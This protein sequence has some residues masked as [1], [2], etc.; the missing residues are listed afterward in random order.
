MAKKNVFKKAVAVL[1][2]ALQ[3]SGFLSSDAQAAP[4]LATVVSESAIQINKL[5]LSE[6]WGR[7]QN[8][9]HG[10][11][12]KTL[13]VIEDA[14][15]VSSAQKSIWKLIE[16]IRARYGA[17]ALHLEGLNESS[18]LALEHSFPDRDWLRKKIEA[19]VVAQ[20][21]SGGAAALILS[22]LLMPQA[23]ESKELYYRAVE[24]YQSAIKKQESVL[25]R[26]ERAREIISKSKQKSY[27]T[28][29]LKWDRFISED[30]FEALPLILQFPD[31]SFAEHFPHLEAVRRQVQIQNHLK[32]PAIVQFWQRCLGSLAKQ[33]A[34]PA[35]RL[36]LLA[37]QK[38]VQTGR[39]SV[40]QSA[41]K[42]EQLLPADLFNKVN[43]L[44]KR[45]YHFALRS[46]REW[47]EIKT[48][49]L[50]AEYQGFLIQKLS[51][52]F[53]KSAQHLLLKQTLRIRLLEKLVRMELSLSDWQ[54]VKRMNLESP[55]WQSFKDFYAVQFK[56]EEKMQKHIAAS[57][58][59]SE[60]VVFVSGGFHKQG[61][62]QIAQKQ[63][64]NFAVITPS[65]DSLEGADRYVELMQGNIGWRS[66]MK[67][68]NGQVNLQKA[69]WSYL[70]QAYAKDHPGQVYDL[71]LNWRKRL[72]L[73]LADLKKLNQAVKIA[74]PLHGWLADFMSEPTRQRFRYQWRSHLKSPTTAQAVSQAMTQSPFLIPMDQALPVNLLVQPVDAVRKIA[75]PMGASTITEG[76]WDQAVQTVARDHFFAEKEKKIIRAWKWIRSSFLFE[77]LVSKGLDAWIQKN[78]VLLPREYRIYWVGMQKVFALSFSAFMGIGFLFLFDDRFEHFRQGFV[79][80]TIAAVF[81]IG[82]YWMGRALSSVAELYDFFVS[83]RYEVENTAREI[84]LRDQE[85]SHQSAEL[86]S[87]RNVMRSETRSDDFTL[88]GRDAKGIEQKKID[89]SMDVIRG[90]TQDVTVTWGIPAYNEIERLHRPS[91]R[92]PAGED[93][94]RVKFEQ[95]QMLRE[96]NPQFH[97]RMVFVDDGSPDLETVSLLKRLRRSSKLDP[98]QVQIL[99]LAP[100]VK[101]G[102]KGGAVHLGLNAAL[103]SIRPRGKHYIGY[104][105]MD[106]SANLLLTGLLI[107]PMAETV[108]NG[109]AIGVRR[110]KGSYTEGR[111]WQALISSLMYNWAIRLLLSPI[112]NIRDTQAGFKIFSPE[113]LRAILP[114][115]RDFSFSFDSELLLLAALNK[116]QIAQVP[117]AW[118]DSVAASTFAAQSVNRGFEA[119]KTVAN[120]HAGHIREVRRSELREVNEYLNQAREG[121]A[122]LVAEVKIPRTQ[123]SVIVTIVPGRMDAITGQSFRAKITYPYF[124]GIFQQWEEFGGAVSIN[125]RDEGDKKVYEF[126]DV[127]PSG[128]WAD[129]VYELN[130]KRGVGGA[131][132]RFLIGAVGF[133]QQ[134][135]FEIDITRVYPL[136]LIFEKYSRGLNFSEIISLPVKRLIPLHW[137]NV[138]DFWIGRDAFSLEL[139][140]D[141][142][143]GFN[144]NDFRGRSW[145]DVVDKFHSPGLVF[146]SAQDAFFMPFE[147]IR[148]VKFKH[149][150]DGDRWI[151]ADV[152][153]Q[154]LDY[155]KSELIGRRVRFD[156]LTN[157]VMVITDRGVENNIGKIRHMDRYVFVRGQVD[158]AKISD[159]NFHIV[160]GYPIRRSESR[161]VLDGPEPGREPQVKINLN[162]KQLEFLNQYLGGEKLAD[163]AVAKIFENVNGL[164][165]RLNQDLHE[166]R[167]GDLVV[168]RP[169]PGAASEFKKARGWQPRGHYLL[170]V[171]DDSFKYFASIRDGSFKTRSRQPLESSGWW[172]PD[173]LRKANVT[174][175]SNLR[176]S[177]QAEPSVFALN[178]KERPQAMRDEPLFLSPDLFD[179]FIIRK[180]ESTDKR[181]EARE[182]LKVGWKGPFAG[183]HFEARS[184]QEIEA[185]LL[186]AANAKQLDVLYVD[187]DNTTFSTRGWHGSEGQIQSL[188]Q[189]LTEKFS[190]EKNARSM[191]ARLVF[192]FVDKMHAWMK[193]N[194]YFEPASDLDI[195]FYQ[196]LRKKGVRIVAVT[197]RPQKIR[198]E[199]IAT[200][201]AIFGE[202]AITDWLFTDGAGI[203]KLKAIQKHLESA[204]IAKDHALLV[205]DFH[206][207]VEA[208]DSLISTIHL[209]DIYADEK[210]L[211]VEK[212]FA[213]MRT[214]PAQK[215]LR[216][217]YALNA[218]VAA[219]DGDH[220]RQVR[221]RVRPELTAAMNQGLDQAVQEIQDFLNRSNLTW[222]EIRSPALR[223]SESRLWRFEDLQLSVRP[224][225]F[226]AVSLA[227]TLSE[228]GAKNQDAVLI[229]RD[230]ELMLPD[231][232][233]QGTGD[234]REFRFA[235][236]E[237]D[238]DGVMREHFESVRVSYTGGW[239]TLATNGSEPEAF[240]N[241]QKEEAVYL[242]GYGPNEIGFERANGDETLV[243]LKSFPNHKAN[244][245]AIKPFRWGDGIKV[246]VSE[247]AGLTRS[248]YQ[249]SEAREG[250]SRPQL[251]Q[252]KNKPEWLDKTEDARFAFKTFFGFAFWGVIFGVAFVAAAVVFTA[253]A[254]IFK[255]L[256]AY[257]DLKNAD[258]EY[259][260]TFAKYSDLSLKEKQKAVEFSQEWAVRIPPYAWIAYVS[261]KWKITGKY[262][263]P[264]LAAVQAYDSLLSGTSGRVR[265]TG[266]FVAKKWRRQGLKLA[267]RLR[268]RFFSDMKER[269]ISEVWIEVDPSEEAQAFHRNQQKRYG[270]RVF[271]EGLSGRN[272]LMRMGGFQPL[273]ENLVNEV[274][275]RIP[276]RRSEARAAK[277]KMTISEQADALR[278]K[279]IRS[280]PNV[281]SD[282]L[283]EELAHQEVTRF[284]QAVRGAP[285]M[286]NYFDHSYF[287]AMRDNAKDARHT[288]YSLKPGKLMLEMV[289]VP[290]LPGNVYGVTFFNMIDLKDASDRGTP[291]AYAIYQIFKDKD[292]IKTHSINAAFNVFK[293][294]RDHSTSKYA[295]KTHDLYNAWLAGLVSRNPIHIRV[296]AESQITKSR[297]GDLYLRVLFN[298][299]RGYYPPDNK[300]EA[301]RLF[302]DIHA[303]KDVTHKRVDAF[304]KKTKAQHWILPVQ[305]LKQRTTANRSEAR[306]EKET[307]A[308][309]AFATVVSTVKEGVDM[310]WPE[311]ELSA[312]INNP[313]PDFVRLIKAQFDGRPK[314]KGVDLGMGEG[315]FLPQAQTYFAKAGLQ[316]QM[317]GTENYDAHST[318][319]EFLKEHGKGSMDFVSVNSPTPRAGNMAVFT[320]MAAQL[321]KDDGLVYVASDHY[322]NYAAV[323]VLL[324]QGFH[325]AFTTV[326]RNG[327]DRSQYDDVFTAVV[328]SRNNLAGMRYLHDQGWKVIVVSRSEVRKIN[329]QYSDVAASDKQISKK[330]F[331]LHIAIGAV[332]W[333]LIELASWYFGFPFIFNLYS[334]INSF[335]W[336]DFALG[337]L[338]ASGLI[339]S[340]TG[341]IADYYTQLISDYPAY[342]YHVKKRF[343]A[344]MGV[345]FLT[346]VVAFAANVYWVDLFTSPLLRAAISGFV[347]VSFSSLISVYFNGYW[348]RRGVA[349]IKTRG[350]VAPDKI[351]ELQAAYSTRSQWGKDLK[352]VWGRLPVL[353]AQHHI[354]QDIVPELLRIP[355]IFTLG[356]FMQLFRN[357]MVNSQKPSFDLKTYL[358]VNLSVVGLIFILG[359]ASALSIV[360]ASIALIGITVGYY[361]LTALKKEV[362]NKPSQ[363]H[364][365]E[366][367]PEIK[368]HLFSVEESQAFFQKLLQELGRRGLAMARDGADIPLD[369]ED[370]LHTNARAFIWDHGTDVSGKR[371]YNRFY[372][373]SRRDNLGGIIL[374]GDQDIPILGYV[375]FNR[376]GEK[377]FQLRFQIFE[378][379]AGLPGY[380]GQGHG[381]RLVDFL[382]IYF[383]TY[384]NPKPEDLFF[385]LSAEEARQSSVFAVPLQRLGFEL[386]E[387]PQ[388]L[389]LKLNRSEM[390]GKLDEIYTE[391]ESMS[392]TLSDLRGLKEDVMN[393]FESRHIQKREQKDYLAVILAAA[394][395]LYILGR[396]AEAF[397]HEVAEELTR[398][399]RAVDVK[400]ILKNVRQT[401][402]IYGPFARID[403][404]YVRADMSSLLR[405]PKL[406]QY[407][408]D[409]I[410]AR[411]RGKKLLSVGIGIG[412]LE[413]D[414]IRRYGAEV[415]GTDVLP[416][417]LQI[418][419]QSEGVRSQIIT[420]VAHG[421]LLPFQKQ[422]YDTVIYPESIGHLDLKSA[423]QDA[424]R[425]LKP[426][427]SIFIMTYPPESK[428]AEGFQ[429]RQY[430][431]D[432]IKDALSDFGFQSISFDLTDSKKD[433]WVISAVKLQRSETRTSVHPKKYMG[434]NDRQL[435]ETE[436]TALLSEMNKQGP[437]PIVEAP[438]AAEVER[439]FRLFEADAKVTQDDLEVIIRQAVYESWEALLKHA[440]PYMGET[441]SWSVHNGKWASDQYPATHLAG[442]QFRNPIL[443]LSADFM[444][445]WCTSSSL[446]FHRSLYSLSAGKIKSTIHGASLVFGGYLRHVVQVVQYPG[447]QPI[448]VD[449]TGRQL[450]SHAMYR[451]IDATPGAR[452][453][454]NELFEKG[455]VGL[456]PENAEKIGLVFRRGQAREEGSDYDVLTKFRTLQ[457]GYTSHDYTPL[458]EYGHEYFHAM[459]P[460]IAR[461]RSALDE[462][463]APEL[464]RDFSGEKITGMWPL[465]PVVQVVEQIVEAIA[466]VELKATDLNQTNNQ[467][468]KN[469]DW[470]AELMDWRI[471]MMLSGFF[472]VVVSALSLTLNGVSWLRLIPLAMSVFGF[473]ALGISFFIKIK[474]LYRSGG[475]FDSEFNQPDSSLQFP[476]SNER[477]ETRSTHS[478]QVR[479][480][481]L[482]ADDQWFF[483]LLRD[484]SKPILAQKY[485]IL[486]GGL[487]SVWKKT[488]AGIFVPSPMDEV[489]QALKPI[490]T[491]EHDFIDLGSGLN[492]SLIVAAHLGVHKAVGIEGDESL[493]A[494]GKVLIDRFTVEFERQRIG[495]GASSQ[496]ASEKIATINGNFLDA[497]R[498][499]L[500]TLNGKIE[501]ERKRIYYYFAGGSAGLENMKHRSQ[502]LERIENAP[503]GSYF[504]L[505]GAQ[506]DMKGELDVEML[507]EKF[508]DPRVMTFPN[509]SGTNTY[510][511]NIGRSEARADGQRLQDKLRRI[512]HIIGELEDMTVGIEAFTLMKTEDASES[513]IKISFN[514]WMNEHRFGNDIGF[515]YKRELSPDEIVSD[516]SIVLRTLDLLMLIESDSN[517]ANLEKYK[518]SKIFLDD[519]GESEDKPIPYE[520][521]GVY[522][523]LQ[524]YLNSTEVWNPFRAKLDE[525]KRL[526][527]EEGTRED[528][529][530]L[531][532]SVHRSETRDLG[533]WIGSD[534]VTPVYSEERD[535]EI[536][537]QDWLEAQMAADTAIEVRLVQQ[538]R[539]ISPQAKALWQQALTRWKDAIAA[540]QIP[541][542][543]PVI[544]Y[545]PEIESQLIEFIELTQKSF[546]TLYP[547]QST[548]QYRF[549]LVFRTDYE[550]ATFE[551]KFGKLKQVKMYGPQ[552]MGQ[553]ATDVFNSA[554]WR[555]HYGVFGAREILAGM[556]WQRNLSAE[557]LPTEVSF[558][559]VPEAMAFFAATRTD[560]IEAAW[561]TGFARWIQHLQIRKGEGIFLLSSVL[562]LFSAAARRVMTSA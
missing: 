493:F 364:I 101:R 56:R 154:D 468:I 53:T 353:L 246:N 290:V 63:G 218:L 273:P 163:Y 81:G 215:W 245:I 174:D 235:V 271:I 498:I 158:P 368:S 527:E 57:F 433:Y 301:D 43:A 297:L 356:L 185:M 35:E 383:S 49:E 12:G 141:Q 361:A 152:D 47:Q 486:L 348:N 374:F 106:I 67:A 159:L 206:E 423:V 214:V 515:L 123:A 435:S 359:G 5:Q 554:K 444:V 203:E 422:S 553:L 465:N 545:S 26:L 461:E 131:V 282:A 244:Y 287:T 458:Q 261:S 222:E 263:K 295:F 410:G 87:G 212:Y 425:V 306:G 548:K 25:V 33:V 145:E 480:M 357:Y 376:I 28:E 309:D 31:E 84:K 37:L 188:I 446:S 107:K 133:D 321:V 30:S 143:Q 474:N 55:D 61:L 135:H 507:K 277:S 219:R 529:V 20:N 308:T 66:Q 421:E 149:E 457:T 44:E 451:D 431:Q 52:Y 23:A 46:E 488:W 310:L 54:T 229:P 184:W 65:I 354:A 365:P 385:Y 58:R 450:E 351:D 335:Y 536:R 243:E 504:V 117:I 217:E 454:F 339:A 155:D 237:A 22:D 477:S 333:G 390:R 314:L 544:F 534:A 80:G 424:S 292:G 543:A 426:G 334:W 472:G 429:Y 440:G 285:E 77:S 484:V 182:K 394:V 551:K 258:H 122:P 367:A 311:G 547:G 342:Q 153:D 505:Y 398:A 491:G 138:R 389:V 150:K 561:A 151:L 140:Y 194:G 199:T 262:G 121:D 296:D 329:Q 459:T 370:V 79:A 448:Y 190:G 171:R 104:T 40:T 473:T 436:E 393:A 315:W 223:R 247:L 228:F 98:Q 178:G 293:A 109:A 88:R 100:S 414:L 337:S 345:R 355:T 386:T 286:E 252:Q 322:Q 405:Y 18:H 496:Y 102:P 434:I 19:D 469:I 267:T 344:F 299:S 125:V 209:K 137:K 562:E 274:K 384:F 136:L 532:R 73:R 330:R 476:E 369:H 326:F 187:L 144:L 4:R 232:F 350:D 281:R 266:L 220:R 24:L 520:T 352:G 183:R 489:I 471:P 313:I 535:D 291:V 162:R 259:K 268:D 197:A 85:P 29:A 238:A 3:L 284:A 509:G 513:V 254:L 231:R 523:L 343:T 168:F 224:S 16:D 320:E 416:E 90:L 165:Y 124:Q 371:N 210:H 161:F 256:Q 492:T 195:G 173:Q 27:S 167:A 255:L 381:R 514:S 272:Y 216:L 506:P 6:K 198:P 411:S 289:S 432:E 495:F 230:F 146:A 559:L 412:A 91:A 111:N 120:I 403:P 119:L 349:E 78:L 519:A 521:L 558:A 1:L 175:F 300:E 283:A 95:L 92:Y 50:A 89:E 189:K 105:D 462:A 419:N 487:P 437:L 522:F 475:A 332:A 60:T 323:R 82:V 270:E 518:S 526:W 510:I 428:L 319:E 240:L 72:I 503:A 363:A 516:G 449:V 36:A 208:V 470:M 382:K 442:I 108:L 10:E 166:I 110:G 360:A 501:P 549:A 70:L 443:Y 64:W 302:L 129:P 253:G 328:A 441:A 276:V 34:G 264:E 204:G 181:S 236:V 169:K 445:G 512:K 340:V 387:N 112:S 395:R 93:A 38:D 481:N 500:I 207:N 251:I 227:E 483:D 226:D 392:Y 269:G 409:Q 15:A 312:D 139:E 375:V 499:N 127:Y 132:L 74:E 2:I 248:I 170:P 418:I 9:K 280:L 221:E 201:T 316:I 525:L 399:G 278:L 479:D 42:L 147:G 413:G 7:I 388:S 531:I 307:K 17:F 317:F 455:Y 76:V 250:E 379:E 14:H 406:R 373:W 546:E 391:V 533:I 404:G 156:P 517:S 456:S 41:Q 478:G 362:L 142:K 192:P 233:F 242:R 318:N 239:F 556:A 402:R 325:V 45:L 294:Y 408:A 75:N 179:F 249:R 396:P 113:T 86:K 485:Q 304:L 8:R 196:E 331:Y 420:V 555:D 186:R 439:V 97:W 94:F 172:T 378:P 542:T 134:G 39:L 557:S 550:R 193:K 130:R 407:V 366:S 148:K 21:I 463:Y 377:S 508:G 494:D 115:A 279:I 511:F 327:P 118:F 180:P 164:R 400:R 336:G 126:H 51:T 538:A 114:V 540:K 225:K 103:N 347:G 176:Q 202:G 260:I 482:S 68:V 490:V 96:I 447:L 453:L 358:R 401:Q 380:R 71:L 59:S 265:T 417:F 452:P 438:P 191:A 560:E 346:G 69:Y 427:G 430:S 464:D 116:K 397:A 32:R 62:E 298:L 234:G 303:H 524:M 128:T 372:R 539:Q 257:S 541:K 241:G 467:N 211:S 502:L 213:R 99:R 11:S 177:L 288:L 338:V 157:N 205:D 530:E 415:T 275:V 305:D 13:L 83:H 160:S 341:A 200:T 552:A 324:E 497:S 537:F 48:A 460:E 528:L 466:G